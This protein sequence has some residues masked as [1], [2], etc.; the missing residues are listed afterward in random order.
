MTY[1]YAMIDPRT[2]EV[3]YVGKTSKGLEYRRKGHINA[4]KYNDNTYLLRWLRGLLNTGEKP[5]MQVLEEVTEDEWRDAE[6]KWIA[7]GRAR[8]WLLTN[9]TEGGEGLCNPSPETR[10]KLADA[11]RGNTHASGERSE[12]FKRRAA[13]I[14]RQTLNAL[15]H[16]VSESTRQQISENL[17]A[18][19]QNGG[20]TMCGEQNGHARFTA[21]D[22]RAI[23]AEYAQG[24]ISYRALGS[25]HGVCH[26][27]I[28]KLVLHKTW[29]HID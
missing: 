19:Y 5:V 1:I 15:G 7:R 17:K 14:A 26:E 9:G 4:A 8:G 23:R 21:D 13:E 16:T 29:G 6:R 3:R 25:R 24:G 27:T 22:V 18:Y 2:D 28:R 10:R 12:A 20:A 11:A